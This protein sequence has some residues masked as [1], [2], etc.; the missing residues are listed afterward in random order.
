MVEF[1]CEALRAWS[2][3][4]AKLLN[5]EC[6]FFKKYR[7]INIFCFFLCYFGYYIFIGEPVNFILVVK[8]IIIQLLTIF[9]Y[10]YFNIWE[11]V[12][13]S[14]L[15]A[16]IDKLF[17]IFFLNSLVRDLWFLLIFPKISIFIFMHS[18]HC[19][20]FLWPFFTVLFTIC[21]LLCLLGLLCSFFKTWIEREYMVLKKQ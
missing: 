14:S 4:C 6:N 17:F 5:Y 9:L 8:F 7:V 12:M 1:T 21:F 13:V 19:L 11:S 2:F 20:V 10:Y 16:D 15:I 18:S 3:L